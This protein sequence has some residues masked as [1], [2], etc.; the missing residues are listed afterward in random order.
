ML[1]VSVIFSREINRTRYFWSNL[2]IKSCNYCLC[3]VSA[4]TEIFGLL[5]LVAKQRRG[6]FVLGVMED[7]L[8]DVKLWSLD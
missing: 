7:T 8:P 5:A 6:G 4:C 2:H 1:Y 3:L